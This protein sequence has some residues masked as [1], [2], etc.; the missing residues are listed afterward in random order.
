[1]LLNEPDMLK[2]EPLKPGERAKKGGTSLVGSG[3]LWLLSR[4]LSKAGASGSTDPIFR[5]NGFAGL[6]SL[7]DGVLGLIWRDRN[8][9][10]I[11]VAPMLQSFSRTGASGSKDPIFFLKESSGVEHPTPISVSVLELCPRLRT[12]ASPDSGT[13]G[14]KLS[15][16]ELRPRLRTCDLG[17]S[18]SGRGASGGSSSLMATRVSVLELFSRPRADGASD[19]VR[20]RRSAHA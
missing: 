5:I 17:G 20:D 18:N 10:P 9:I 15:V 3:V 6:A 13:K 4:S 12:G 16:L 2:N 19:A 8:G 7:Y 1:M 14:N 11:P